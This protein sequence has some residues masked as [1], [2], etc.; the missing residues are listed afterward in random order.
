MKKGNM[1]GILCL[2]SSRRYPGQFTDQKEQEAKRL[3]AKFGKSSIFIYDKRLWEIKPKGTFGNE[4]FWVFIGDYTRNPKILGDDGSTIF[5][6]D[7]EFVLQIPEEFRNDFETDI[8]S[9]LR[10]IAGVSTLA[11]HPFISNREV[12]GSAF[13]KRKVS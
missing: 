7:D 8:H 10:D 11:I 13:G 12:V 6:N 1:P 5:Q 3:I 2:V 9:A 4:F